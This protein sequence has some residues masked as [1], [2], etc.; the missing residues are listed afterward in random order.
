[1]PSPTRRQLLLG[2]AAAPIALSLSCSGENGPRTGS[3]EGPGRPL[4]IPPLAPSTVDSSGIRRFTLRAAPGSTEIVDGR[5]TATWGY[6]G[7]ILGP[8]LRARRGETVAVEFENGLPAPTTLHWHGMHLPARCDG[9]PH[10]TVQPGDRWEPSWTV[11]QPA[12]TLWYHPHPHGETEKHVYRGLAGLFII[13]DDDSPAGL[14]H[15]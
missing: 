12:A 6:N 15:D 14:P 2:L 3:A 1:V 4:P 13:D 8:T 7:S 5:R 9:G 10:Q 11:R